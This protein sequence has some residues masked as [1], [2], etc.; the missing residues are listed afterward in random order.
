MGLELI[1]FQLSDSSLVIS[2]IIILMSS[3][4]CNGLF[5]NLPLPE[6]SC[7][8]N[9]IRSM[10]AT[11]QR[12]NISIQNKF[13]IVTFFVFFHHSASIIISPTAFRPNSVCFNIFYHATKSGLSLSYLFF[14]CSL[15]EFLSSD[16]NLLPSRHS[17]LSSSGYSVYCPS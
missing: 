9:K 4:F 10:V 3:S 12:S 13:Q 11:N 16:K 15:V 1:G 5:L 14:N 7:N 2:P 6:I 17:L 8:V